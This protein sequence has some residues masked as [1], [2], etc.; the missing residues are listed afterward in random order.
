LNAPID[1]LVETAKRTLR[2]RLLGEVLPPVSRTPVSYMEDTLAA[3][4]TG[5]ARG[6]AWD[7]AEALWLL[8]SVPRVAEGFLRGLDGLT[9]F[10]NKAMLVPVI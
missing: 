10:G 9:T 5:S 8:Q 4:V 2:V 3:W 6:Q 7:H 1:A